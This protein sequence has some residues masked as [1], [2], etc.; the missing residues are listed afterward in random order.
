MLSSH[1]IGTRPRVTTWVIYDR[2][3]DEMLRGSCRFSMAN[4]ILLT[5]SSEAST[6]SDAG[7]ISD[8]R[9]SEWGFT[10]GAQNGIFQK[11]GND[12]NNLINKTPTSTPADLPSSTPLESNPSSTPPRS[13]PSST[14]KSDPSS[15]P[16][17]NDPS[18]TPAGDRPTPTPTPAGGNSVNL[19]KPSSS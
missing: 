3:R 15:S 19:P 5:T 9:F 4:M 13:D 10:D 8:I 2:R 7:Q 1:C 11:S 16:P 12:T 18:S 14:P 17:R 6:L